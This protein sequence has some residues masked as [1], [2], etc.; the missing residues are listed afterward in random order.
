MPPM[1]TTVAIS[2]FG[3]RR[4]Q[5][6]SDLHETHGPAATQ[7]TLGGLGRRLQAAQLIHRGLRMGALRSL[8]ADLS[9]DAL[10]RLYREV[11][12]EPAQPGR[13][14]ASFASQVKTPADAVAGVVLLADYLTIAGANHSETIDPS[15]LIATWDRFC[16]LVGALHF[17]GTAVT[18]DVTSLWLLVRDHQSG[19]VTLSTC[20][21]CSRRHLRFAD[22]I[23]LRGHLCPSCAQR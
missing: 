10:R 9:S 13:L 12:G 14:P 23:A 18:I 5:C 3:P 4:N 16:G 22:D 11:R 1:T 17:S 6:V 8:F 20:T 19:E 15:S 2:P 21:G 7:E